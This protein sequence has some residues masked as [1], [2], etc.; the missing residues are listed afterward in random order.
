MA[1]LSRTGVDTA[2]GIITEVLAPTVFVNGSPVAVLGSHIANHGDSPHN[3]ATMVQSSGSVF[4]HGVQVCR[5]G[6]LASC[7]H[8]ATGSG[9]VSNGG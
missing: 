6:D 9:D 2:G 4:A 7:G 5:A 3:N 8:A 1:G